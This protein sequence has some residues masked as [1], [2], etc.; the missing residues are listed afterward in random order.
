MEKLNSE[1]LDDINNAAIDALLS[2]QAT[3]VLG[4]KITGEDFFTV[5]PSWEDRS[6]FTTEFSIPQIKRLMGRVLTVV[7]ASYDS[8][9][10]KFVKD[11]VK[12]EFASC[13]SYIHEILASLEDRED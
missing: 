9:R 5:D 4:E 3:D 10:A 6:T 1:E 8:D 12:S 11:L 2:G 7:D 13:I